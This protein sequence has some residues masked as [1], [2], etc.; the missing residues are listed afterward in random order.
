[1]SKN[2]H[3]NKSLVRKKS[4]IFNHADLVTRRERGAR[5]R[6]VSGVPFDKEDGSVCLDPCGQ[7]CPLTKTQS[8]TSKKKQVTGGCHVTMSEA[9]AA[10]IR[11]V[12]QTCL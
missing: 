10:W 2:H 5:T 4:I 7:R 8:P 3:S 12:W 6:V 9:W 11:V 1:M